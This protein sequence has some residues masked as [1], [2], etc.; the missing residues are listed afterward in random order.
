V[1]RTLHRLPRVTLQ[2]GRAHSVSFYPEKEN[3]TKIISQK[4]RKHIEGC[5]FAK[6]PKQIKICDGVLPDDP[7]EL[8]HDLSQVFDLQEH[9]VFLGC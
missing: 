9:L 1:F 5:S 7:V 8:V 4:R 6:F 3:L 2:R